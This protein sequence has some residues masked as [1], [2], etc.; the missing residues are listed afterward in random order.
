MKRTLLAVAAVSAVVAAPVALAAPGPGHGHG[1]GHAYG[2]GKT[3]SPH[4]KHGN[5]VVSFVL[6][7]TVE[8]APYGASFTLTLKGAN[9]VA[10]KALNGT[11]TFIVLTDAKT[12]F[13][14]A[15]KGAA[16]LA[17]IASNDRVVVTIRAKRS[18]DAAGLALVAAWR[19]VDQGPK[20]A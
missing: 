14:K 1:H 12:H 2:H 15:G 9:A 3:T 18:T 16:S 7:G 17:A 8:G 5:A 20:P 19:V 6:R 13:S 10:K 4:G 11:A